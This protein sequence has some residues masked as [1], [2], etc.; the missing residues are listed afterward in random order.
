MGGATKAT[1]N[2]AHVVAAV[3][4]V[5]DVMVIGNE[6]DDTP[7]ADE[8]VEEMQRRASEVRSAVAA[9]GEVLVERS[10]PGK[11]TLTT[12]ARRRLKKKKKHEK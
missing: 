5:A 6:D 10:D 4:F 8:A 12:A 7:T 2:L 9:E 1:V 3:D 11:L